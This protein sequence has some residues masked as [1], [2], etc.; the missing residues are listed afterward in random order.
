[1]QP[2]SCS[3]IVFRA[4]LRK[5]WI[6]PVSGTVL[7]AAFVRRDAPNDDDGLSVDIASPSSCAAPF[8]ERFGVASLHVGSVRDFTLDIVVDDPPHANIT[9]V[10]RRLED[11][12]RAERLASQLA[13]QARLIGTD[14][15]PSPDG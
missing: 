11:L 13:K 12:T 3:T 1:M 2:L 8:R 4:M 5:K 14:Q 6:D 10:P 15:V 9:G 7:P